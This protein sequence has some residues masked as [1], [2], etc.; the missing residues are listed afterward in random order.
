MITVVVVIHLIV[1]MSMIGLILLQKTEGNASGGGFSASSSMSNMMQP[2]PRANPLGRATVF[3]GIAFFATSLGLAL[4][5]KQ[6][7]PAPS[8]F[9]TPTDASGPKVNEIRTE[10][11]SGVPPA[12]DATGPAVPSETPAPDFGGGPAPAPSVPTAPAGA[13]AVP[14]N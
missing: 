11:V 9:T 7:G 1:A 14:N 13:P 10:P 6:A 5:S 3:L 2:R 12:A 8:I 4:M